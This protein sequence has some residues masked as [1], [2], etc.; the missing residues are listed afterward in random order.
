MEEQSLASLDVRPEVQREYID[1][2]DHGLRNSVWN[3][4]GCS[5]YYLNGS[6]RNFVFYPGFNRRFRARTRT[7]DLAGYR[8]S[9]APDADAADS[10]VS[11]V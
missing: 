2:V 7:V 4:G 3:T 6:G 11:T 1:E 8:T 5:S 9:G 10:R